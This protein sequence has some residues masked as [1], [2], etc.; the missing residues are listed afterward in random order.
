MTNQFDRLLDHVMELG[1][2]DTFTVQPKGAFYRLVVVQGALLFPYHDGSTHRAEPSSTW[3]KPTVSQVVKELFSFAGASSWIQE[4]LEGLDVRTEDEVT[5]RPGLADLPDD[6]RLVL[7]P[8]TMN[9][10]GL[11]QAWWGEAV[12]VDDQGSLEW[13]SG[14]E[15]LPLL[16]AD[17]RTGTRPFESVDQPRAQER[18]DSG[19]LP[20]VLLSARSVSDRQLGIAPMTER[21]TNEPKSQDNDED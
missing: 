16:T 14:P 19:D 12:L 8:Y 17:E 18:F 15:E 11:L 6:T 21:Q 5:L 10:S 7:I 9:L 2:P 3:P 1:I 13:K 20:E 4:S